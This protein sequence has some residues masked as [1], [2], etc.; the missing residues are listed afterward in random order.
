M[1]EI[2]VL[3]LTDILLQELRMWEAVEDGDAKLFDYILKQPGKD[4]ETAER[5]RTTT[6]LFDAHI[7]GQVDILKVIAKHKKEDTFQPSNDMITDVYH[8]LKPELFS[9]NFTNFYSYKKREKI[10]KY[11]NSIRKLSGIAC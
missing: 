11:F 1:S 10:E 6:S 7:H 3:R 4:P 8:V 5:K 2:N 9:Y